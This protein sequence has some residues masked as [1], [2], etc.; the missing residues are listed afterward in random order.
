MAKE[1]SRYVIMDKKIVEIQIQNIVPGPPILM[2]IAIPARDPTPILEDR[3][4]IKVSFGEILFV[5][6]VFVMLFII[7]I[8]LNWGNFSFI[9]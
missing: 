8:I 9:V 7:E 2:A 4:I 6:F 3:A 1:F 5:F